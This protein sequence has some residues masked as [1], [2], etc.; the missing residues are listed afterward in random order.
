MRYFMTYFKEIVSK[1]RDAFTDAEKQL[2][3]ISLLKKHI[4]TGPA[5][6]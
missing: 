3:I 6:T 1:Y 4:Y 5:F 2:L